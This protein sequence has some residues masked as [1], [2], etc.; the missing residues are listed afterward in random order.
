M[1]DQSDGTSQIVEEGD[2]FFVYRPRV[3][4]QEPSDLEDVQ[5]FHIVLRPQSGGRVRSL[6]AGRKHLPDP[7]SHERVWGF[8]DAVA[9]K[10]SDLEPDFRADKYETGTRGKQTSPSMRPAGEGRYV[11]S[12]EEGQLHLSYKLELPENRGEVAEAFNI[13]DEASYA[14]SIKNPEK[15]QPKGAGLSKDQ[16]ADYPEELQKKF[17]DRRF[18]PAD[19]ELLDYEGAEFILIGARRNPE[20]EYD[21]EIDT[22]TENYE[23]SEA[24]RRLKMVKSRHPV[25]PLF[26]GGWA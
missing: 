26:E 20:E 7:K 4:E 21:I 3:N 16:K 23:K 8:V 15:G 12:L 24:V 1:A 25:E 22:E 13:L 18:S 5:R 9:D 19:M 17:R 2:I 6:I 10:A 11:V 14:L